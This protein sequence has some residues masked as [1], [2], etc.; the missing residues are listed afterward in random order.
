MSEK[1]G[2]F[3]FLSKNQY[4]YLKKE[5]KKIVQKKQHLIKNPNLEEML[6][7]KMKK[8]VD[9]F[10][11]LDRYNGMQSRIISEFKVYKDN[12]TQKLKQRIEEMM[13]NKKGIGNPKQS[14]QNFK[15]YID[16]ISSFEEKNETIRNMQSEYVTISNYI[17]N[18]SSI[19]FLLLGPH[20]SGKS[21][22]L[23]NIIGYNQNYLPTNNNECT[24]VGVIIKYANKNEEIKMYKT[25]LIVDLKNGLNYFKYL[26]KKVIAEG[27]KNEIFRN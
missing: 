11:M 22:L 19:R 12:N 3:S 10:F 1:N 23:N 7:A 15:K 14:I 9:D 25:E 24:K 21:S 2:F 17:N 20:S 26:E 13:K 18:S 27:S 8:I 6:K 5:F 4:I 16:L